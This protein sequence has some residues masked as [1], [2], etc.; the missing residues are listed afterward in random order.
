MMHWRNGGPLFRAFGECFAALS[1]IE[2]NIVGSCPT[3]P[4]GLWIAD[5]SRCAP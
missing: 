1:K 3:V 5:V 2:D 4:D